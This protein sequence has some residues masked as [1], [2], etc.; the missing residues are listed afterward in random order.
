MKTHK[1]VTLDE[2]DACAFYIGLKLAPDPIHFKSSPVDPMTVIEDIKMGRHRE[3][4]DNLKR[5]P[6]ELGRAY[7]E[8]EDGAKLL[9]CRGCREFNRPCFLDLEEFHVDAGQCPDCKKKGS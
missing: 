4:F 7:L 2:R 1:A 5:Q 9:Y 6:K 3:V 8:R